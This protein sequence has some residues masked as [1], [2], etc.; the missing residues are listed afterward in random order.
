MRVVLK[1]DVKGVGQAG[2]IKEVA[3]G[4]A[5]NFLIPRGLAVPA[6]PAAVEEARARKE[7]EARRAAARERETRALADRIRSTPVTIKARAGEQHRLYGSVTAADIA[8]ALG[9]ALGQEI[10]K[11]NVHL[12]EPIRRLG[13]YQVTIRVGPGVTTE[14]TVNVVPE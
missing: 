8:E 3:D 4:Y 14:V 10:D 7:A 11:R 5:R 6:T 2:D 1:Q 9:K 12:E 13:T